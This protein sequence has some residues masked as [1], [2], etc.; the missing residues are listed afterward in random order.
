MISEIVMPNLGATGGDVTLDGWLVKPGD[1]VRAGQP[2]FVVTTD[3]ATVEVEAFRD[4]VLRVVR[5]QAG[6]TVS[7]GT[8]VGL[9]A[10]TMDESLPVVKVQPASQEVSAPP[11]PHNLPPA[12]TQTDRLLISPLARRMA[13]QEGLNPEKIVGSGRGGQILKRDVVQALATRRVESPV[14]TANGA[15]REI[16]S[17]MRRAIAERTKLSKSD[18]PHFYATITIDMQ[19]ALALRQQVVDWTSEHGWAPPTITDLC[20]RA[21]ALALRDLP[22]L[23]ARF[24]GDAILYHEDINLGLVVGLDDGMLIPVIRQADRLNLTALAA[25]TRRLRQR[26]ESGQLS[27][28]ELAGG[29]FTLSNLG[30]F[31]LDSFTAVINPPEA[32]ILALGAVKVQPAVV[33]GVVVPRP[34]M[35]ATLSVDHRVVDGITAARFVAAFKDLLE[36]PFR[37]TLDAPQETRS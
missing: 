15:R 2:L 8:V 26:A 12:P 1:A 28:N 18:T 10:D 16:L 19:A 17:P 6:E 34:L 5:V 30:M 9:L 36:N 20:L 7:L 22:V 33:D 23:N 4:G 32:G 29:T 11:Q 27:A 13:E 35:V 25:E 24:D 21:T 14:A 31:G 37:L 3:K